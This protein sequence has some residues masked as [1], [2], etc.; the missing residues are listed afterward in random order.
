VSTLYVTEPGA[1]IE[2]E[3]H[4]IL[5]TKEDEVLARVPLSRVSHV[6]LVGNVGATTPALLALLD[7]NVRLAL[8]SRSGQLRGRLAPPLAL[9]MPLR[10]AQ[11]QSEGDPDFCLRLARAI[12]AGKLHN[13]RT[14]L[15][16]LLRRQETL[17]QD[18]LPRVDQ[19]LQQVDQ[20]ESLATLR[21]LEGSAA[22]A[23]FGLLRQAL[24][25]ELAESFAKRAR[26]PPPDPVNSLLGLGY[27]LLTEAMM[28]SLEVVGLDPY[29]GFFHADKYGRPALALDLIEEFRAPIVDSL[30]LTLVNKRMLGPEDFEEGAEEEGEGKEGKVGK[31]EDVGNDG[32]DRKVGV[33]LNHHGR[34]IFFREFADRLESETLHPLA[35][36]RLSYRKIFEVQARL[37]AKVISGEAEAYRPFVWR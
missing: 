11:M 8:V 2:K 37:A 26:R 6:V 34:R 5:V 12:V 1:R 16:R 22:R 32:K 35:G 36:R 33:Y 20:A 27:T 25:S 15:Q 19:A 7:N 13:S 10:R 17:P 31:E 29:I 9:N 3:Y 18:L 24:R 23:Y 28:T 14:L 4:Q 30:V 21:G